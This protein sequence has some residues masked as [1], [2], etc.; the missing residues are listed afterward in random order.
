MVQ[1]EILFDAQGLFVLKPS[2]GMFERLRQFADEKG[3]FDGVYRVH[4]TTSWEHALLH[5][6]TAIMDPSRTT[7]IGVGPMS[8]PMSIMRASVVIQVDR[9]CRRRP[10]PAEPIL[11]KLAQAAFC[12]QLQHRR[13]HSSH[14]I[15][16]VRLQEVCF[17]VVQSPRLD[18]SAKRPIC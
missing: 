4:Y 12:L 14:E 16:G 1:D 7:Y 5:F 6:A 2:E 3:S 17:L 18:V 15:W 8:L 11:R 13:L 9:H 10:G